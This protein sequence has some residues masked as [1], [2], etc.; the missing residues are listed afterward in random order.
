[1]G[2]D[3]STAL[4]HKTSKSKI[5]RQQETSS[6]SIN[7]TTF[8]Y[9]FVTT[10]SWTRHREI[11]QHTTTFWSARELSWMALDHTLIGR[12]DALGQQLCELPP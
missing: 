5:I 12:L 6:S 10:S 4:D 1:M 7:A 9:I 3:H 8:R 2:V 11:V